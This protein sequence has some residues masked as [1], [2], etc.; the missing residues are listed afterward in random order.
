M[1]VEQSINTKKVL[2][3]INKTIKEVKEGIPTSDLST[4]DI[5]DLQNDLDKVKKLA[6]ALKDKFQ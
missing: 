2:T 5:K 6:L 4:E 1:A 3:K